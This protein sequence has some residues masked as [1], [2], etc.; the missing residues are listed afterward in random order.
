MSVSTRKLPNS[1]YPVQLILGSAA[2]FFSW[3]CSVVGMDGIIVHKTPHVHP[4]NAFFYLPAP[5]KNRPGPARKNTLERRPRIPR[6]DLQ[7][8]GQWPPP[9]ILSL[10]TP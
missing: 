6:P 5:E 4:Q 9:S 10:S 7:G 1:A 8:Q 3:T 2:R